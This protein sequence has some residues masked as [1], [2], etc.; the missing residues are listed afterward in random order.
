MYAQMHKLQSYIINGAITIGWNIRRLKDSIVYLAWTLPSWSVAIR[1]YRHKWMRTSDGASMFD[2]YPHCSDI[3]EGIGF[4]ACSV[5]ALR[6]AHTR[7][8][9]KTY[10]PLA[11]T[12]MT[13]HELYCLFMGTHVGLSM[14]TEGYVSL[15]CMCNSD[16]SSLTRYVD[17]VGV[18]LDHDIREVVAI[19]FKGGLTVT[20]LTATAR[21]HAQIGYWHHM[22]M[23]AHNYIHFHL[24]PAFVVAVN[25]G[26]IT[27][28]DSITHQFLQPH[29][30]FTL[31]TNSH[32][33]GG[34]VSDGHETD[35]IYQPITPVS[36]D[37][38]DF[39]DGAVTMTHSFYTHAPYPDTSTSHVSNKDGL[40]GHVR[41]LEYGFPFSYDSI[42]LSCLTDMYPEETG[43]IP[44][45]ARTLSLF[46]TA[47][48]RYFKSVRPYLSQ[49]ELDDIQQ[50]TAELMG[51][52]GADAVRGASSDHFFATMMFVAGA[53]HSTDHGIC[54]SVVQ[55]YNMPVFGSQP[56]SENMSTQEP[57]FDRTSLIISENFRRI[58]ID[59]V[60]AP[61]YERIGH[62]QDL[63]R[64]VPG[65]L[66]HP[67]AL[68]RLNFDLDRAKHDI[69]A[70][71]GVDDY[72]IY[73]SVAH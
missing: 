18:Q 5:V 4:D 1:H 11:P 64:A 21:I 60:G 55:K 47:Y 12:A 16:A 6:D 49:P 67:L 14:T 15:A 9:D 65:L 3:F 54:N 59:N 29:V 42:P 2:V 32:G 71:I 28:R 43:Q 51:N 73:P 20:E 57:I 19:V 50:R 36:I 10:M 7:M 31:L 72:Y 70:Y 40:R 66:C 37:V 69:C 22:G 61:F 34:A 30:D 53:F 41:R 27:R 56:F 48:Y 23:H 33:L 8:T 35:L 24:N 62:R 39:N 25:D 17:C 26:P 58:A 52:V 63:M 13:S 45:Y 44:K 38:K 68:K 46:Y